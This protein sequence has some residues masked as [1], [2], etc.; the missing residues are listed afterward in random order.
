MHQ[1]FMFS[2]LDFI[3]CR[4]HDYSEFRGSPGNI[5]YF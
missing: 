3:E 2:L 1:L 4:R 5:L